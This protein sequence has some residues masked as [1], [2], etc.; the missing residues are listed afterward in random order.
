MNADPSASPS[1]L[2]AA[3]RPFDPWFGAIPDAELG[4]AIRAGT[5]RECPRHLDP[6]RGELHLALP[7]VEPAS[8]LTQRGARLTHSPRPER[9]V[10]A[11]RTA[12]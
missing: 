6:L 5:P 3:Y 7:I 2:P 9:R 8:S 4:N 1:I 11:H 12:A 10:D